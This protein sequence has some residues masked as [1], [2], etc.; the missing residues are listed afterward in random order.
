MRLFA[1]IVLLV[2]ASSFLYGEKLMNRETGS[3][4]VEFVDGSVAFGDCFLELEMELNGI[5][6]PPSKK[7]DFDGKEI[8]Y[9][10]DPMF[11]KAFREVYD[12]LCIAN[13]L[14]QWQ[15]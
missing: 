12:P 3:V 5:Y 4:V 7:M 9:M 13:S 1:K 14:Y 15:D 10:S 8:V 11:E 6:I 2:T